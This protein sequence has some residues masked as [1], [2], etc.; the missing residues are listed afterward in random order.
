MGLRLLAG[1]L[2]FFYGLMGLLGAAFLAPVVLGWIVVA[3]RVAKLPGRG[4]CLPSH[5]RRSIERAVVITLVAC[6]VHR[7]CIKVVF[8]RLSHPPAERHARRAEH[9]LQ[10]VEQDLQRFH[11]KYGHLPKDLEGLADEWWEGLEPVDVYWDPFTGSLKASIKP[12]YYVQRDS[13][14]AL[15]YSVGPDLDDDK[16]EKEFTED[17]LRYHKGALEWRG[18]PFGDWLYERY[19]VSAKL[20]GDIIR[21]ISF[22]EWKDV[23]STGD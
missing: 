15:V 10:R 8:D 5:I 2:N 23:N 16:G 21:Q 7:G 19:D 3:A 6:L 13:T 9:Q 17:Q 11:Y 1:F 22:G 18:M 12:L 4:P 14:N 20:D